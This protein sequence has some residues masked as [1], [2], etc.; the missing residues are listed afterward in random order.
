MHCWCVLLVVVVSGGFGV[1]AFH[2]PQHQ[3]LKKRLLAGLGFQT[4]PDVAKMNVSREEYERM[5]RVYLQSV[6]KQRLQEE[7][8][9]AQPPQ[10]FHSIQNE[11]S[12]APSEVAGSEGVLTRDVDS[13]W[14]YFPVHR[15]LSWHGVETA[16]VR[17]V[18]QQH[19]QRARR[20]KTLV[21]RL[22]RVVPGGDDLLL[23]ERQVD[24]PGG[25][26][27]LELDAA[28]AVHAWLDQPH[29]NLGLKIQCKGCRLSGA[30]IDTQERPA[31][32]SDGAVL[33]VLASK[34]A[35]SHSRQRRAVWNPKKIRGTPCKG[36]KNQCCRHS[37]EVV[38]KDFADFNYVIQPAKFDA[39][40]CRGRCSH[41][42]H[43]SYHAYFQSLIWRQDR[44][45]APRLC[46]APHKLRSLEMLVLDPDDH[47]KLKMVNYKDMEVVNC[48]CS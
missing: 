37:M 7:A 39:G 28:A 19:R 47:S 16:V 38:F 45:R 5:Y 17:F 30:N 42:Q 35:S 8:H 32:S 10:T 11:P 14:L 1:Q 15:E 31:N 29:T 2:D 34:F 6:E 21:L 44:S 40:V 26:R 18:V 46:C 41:K 20:R 48:G 4:Q 12:S 25:S 33:N 9:Q 43:T 24:P 13:W 27:W 23:D 22:F 36:N 3:R